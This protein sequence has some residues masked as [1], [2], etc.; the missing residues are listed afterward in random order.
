MDN[1]TESQESQSVAWVAESQSWNIGIWEFPLH[2]LFSLHDVLPHFY[3]L[4]SVLSAFLFFVTFLLSCILSQLHS[5]PVILILAHI[6]CCYDIDFLPL[7]LVFWSNVVKLSL[8]A[9]LFNYPW[10]FYSKNI[11]CWIHL[12]YYICMEIWCFKNSPADMLCVCWC[13]GICTVGG[14]VYWRG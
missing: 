7:I 8:M 11:S 14:I 2:A 6:K 10:L 3:F 12:V 13:I 4:G 9:W 1:H 5:F